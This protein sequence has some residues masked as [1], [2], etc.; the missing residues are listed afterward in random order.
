MRGTKKQPVFLLDYK[1]VIFLHYFC[2][3][4]LRSLKYNVMKCKTPHVYDLCFECFM[5]NEFG[6]NEEKQ[7]FCSVIM[8][9]SFYAFL[10]C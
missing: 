1:T 6:F 10:V 3:K 8:F 9:N 5:T 7:L 4:Y 2:Y